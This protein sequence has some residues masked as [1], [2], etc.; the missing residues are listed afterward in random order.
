MAQQTY[1]AIV[2]NTAEQNTL[3]EYACWFYTKKTARGPLLHNVNVTICYIH[4]S[5]LD[6]GW[7]LIIFPAITRHLITTPRLLNPAISRLYQC[8]LFAC[9][10]C[11]PITQSRTYSSI[12]SS[13]SLTINYVLCMRVVCV[14]LR[15]NTQVLKEWLE[16][17][18]R[19]CNISKYII[20]YL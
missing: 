1:G 3:N 14:I 2:F 19:T 10:W 7:Y 18:R 11:C 4:V 15:A 6:F 17:K 16:L 20:N 12:P 5:H 13:H 9:V 8:Q